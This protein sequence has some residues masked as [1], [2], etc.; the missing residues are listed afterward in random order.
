MSPQLP[1]R[2]IF[3]ADPYG[4]LVEETRDFAIFLLDLR[5]RIASWN[6]GARL[7][8]GY[9]ADEI[10]GE[11]LGR[12]FTPEDCEDGILQRKLETAK[13]Q[14]RAE[15]VRWH[16]RKDGTRF[17]A[18]GIT[19]A[20]YDG[21]GQVVGFS[22]I[23]R[24]DTPKKLVEEELAH[25]AE[26]LQLALDVGQ[27]G[28]WTWDIQRDR[29]SADAN[30]AR[31]FGVSPEVAAGS[32]IENYLRAIHPEDMPRVQASIEQAV[33][34]GGH[35]FEDYRIVQSDGT[36]LWVE[37]RGKIELDE[38]GA[39]LQLNGVL[40]DISERKN[41]ETAL[42]DSEQRYSTLFQAIDSGF[43]VIEVIFDGQN[44][45][46]DY[47]F[48]EVNPAFERQT[49]LTDAGGKTMT[50]LVPGHDD[51]WF[52]IYGQVA[53]TG[54]SVH[55]E[56]HA[57]AMNRFFDVHAFRVGKPQNHRVALLF[58]DITERKRAD[59][60]R[61]TLMQSLE[62]ERALLSAI[63]QSSPSFVC[64]LR[65]PQLVFEMANPAYYQL[66][67]HRELIGKPLLEALPDVAG[68]GFDEL[69]LGVIHSGE[70]AFLSEREVMLQREP[71]GPFEERLVNLFYL[72]LRDADGV[73]SGVFAHGV[74]ITDQVRA[75]QEAETANRVKDEFLATLSHELR[76]PLTAIIGWAS[77]LQGGDLTA[78]ETRRAVE[79]IERNARAQS[80][81]IE[82]ILDVSRV[83]TG[84][85]RLDVQPVELSTLIE[86]A[87]ATLTPAAAA[88]EIRLQRVMDAG[89][90]LV[91]GDPARLSQIVWN[92]LSNAIKFTPK[93]GR[94]QVRL[95]RVN[96]HVEITIE[97]SG[98]GIAPDVLPHV[99]ERFRQADST[100]TRAY[101]GLGLG[102]AIV[103]HLVELH[104]GSV[105]AHSQGLGHGAR[106]TVKLPLVALRATGA[107]FG[108]E[109]RVHPK[110]GGAA[111]GALPRLD[112]LQVLVDDQEDT[113]TLLQAVLEGCGAR[114]TV[115]SSA[116]EALSL[117]PQLCPDV[118]LS[119]IGMPEEDGFSLIKKVRA[120]PKNQGGE[121]PAAALTAFAR[122]EDRVKVLRCGFQIHLPK[123]VEPLELATVVANLAGRQGEE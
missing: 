99:F 64:I 41:I 8:F 25:T 55:F 73:A 33:R 2:E 50:E 102:L 123:P 103:R 1:L 38:N 52:E 40:V 30:L 92:L 11:T 29:V 59:A 39:P 96:S 97:D 113:R 105:E 87:V 9:E 58:T 26:Q 35:F 90:S 112:G 114:A 10:L 61:E 15:D 51:H 69:L 20:L 34:E 108:E 36:L 71:H 115:V 78:A 45:P 88:K 14:G 98:A 28:A 67:G 46:V 57:A 5:G 91:S 48:L 37:A 43:C 23:A 60:E 18:N 95:E 86:D 122:V 16:L 49:G 117:L 68:Q 44:R 75:R 42:R 100:S 84:K 82:D 32:P 77:I 109:Q 56:N 53:L 4:A 19:A 62:S 63:Y 3:G 17:W 65:G 111:V 31:F 27:I 76:T 104:G 13:L 66:V 74:D 83:I 12:L 89:A 119:D 107:D 79:T 22:K 85:L 106:F 118:L 72:P 121:T 80:Q 110:T 81:L 24:D 93:A 120:L 6:Q 47:R 94:V 116:R 21:A 101:G 54:E 7:L 70:P